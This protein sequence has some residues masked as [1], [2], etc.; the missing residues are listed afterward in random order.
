M[1]HDP[2]LKIDEIRRRLGAPRVNI[3]VLWVVVTQLASDLQWALAQID[4]LRAMIREGSEAEPTYYVA[5]V[6]GS[7]SSAQ[8]T[9]KE[10]TLW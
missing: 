9:S 10:D 8:L 5:P 2:L 1:E 4:G 6:G 7:D 3:S